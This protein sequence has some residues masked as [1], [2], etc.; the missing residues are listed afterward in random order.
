M[1][2]IAGLAKVQRGFSGSSL[3]WPTAESPSVRFDEFRIDLKEEKS[4]SPDIVRRDVDVVNTSTPEPHESKRVRHFHY[5]SWPN[6]GV[7]SST[8]GIRMLLREI[9]LV[10]ICLLA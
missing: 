7:P 2:V 1:S 3:Y 4:L 5:T 6:Y 10:R 9:E 8:E